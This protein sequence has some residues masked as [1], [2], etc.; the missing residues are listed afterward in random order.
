MLIG[1]DWENEYGLPADTIKG[2]TLISRL[3][4]LRPLRYSFAQSALLLDEETIQSQSPQFHIP[5][6]APPMLISVGAEEPDEFRRQSF[7][8]YEACLLYTSP[9]PRDATLSRMP[10]SA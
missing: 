2:A 7:D 6:A 3:Y 9:S 4:D 5:T 8:Y 1:T 10:S